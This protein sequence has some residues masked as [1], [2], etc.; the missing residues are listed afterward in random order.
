MAILSPL[1]SIPFTQHSIIAI[2]S[3]NEFVDFWVR[4]L[5]KI[6]D[7]QLILESSHIH[8]MVRAYHLDSGFIETYYILTQWL[9]V[10]LT[11]IGETCGGHIVVFIG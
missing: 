3:S 4:D 2:I 5:L 10:S 1:F 8:L 7:F 11:H 9:E 6:F